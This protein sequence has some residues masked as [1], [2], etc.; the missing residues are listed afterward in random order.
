[1]FSFFRGRERKRERERKPQKK[2]D[3]VG[4]ISFAKNK[5]YRNCKI[6]YMD[7]LKTIHTKDK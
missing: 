2:R 1:M 6:F 3:M 5:E 7:A 4:E